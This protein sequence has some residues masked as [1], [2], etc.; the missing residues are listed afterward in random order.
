MRPDLGV[1]SASAAERPRPFAARGAL[2]AAAVVGRHPDRL[3]IEQ[4]PDAWSKALGDGLSVA[5][6]EVAAGARSAM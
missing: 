6:S 2:P 5:C 4:L 1:A 3:G